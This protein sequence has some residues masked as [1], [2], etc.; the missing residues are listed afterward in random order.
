M[1]STGPIAEGAMPSPEAVATIVAPLHA[2]NRR[3]DIVMHARDLDRDDFLEIGRRH[4]PRRSIHDR[5]PGRAIV[6]PGL[7]ASRS[8]GDLAAASP[9]PLLPVTR[10]A[11]PF[12]SAIVSLLIL[13]CAGA[14]V[15]SLRGE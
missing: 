14:F 11:F 2:R 9:M 13:F 7:V 4:V 8:A 1:E 15:D 5:R 12:R 6:T 3:D 10:L